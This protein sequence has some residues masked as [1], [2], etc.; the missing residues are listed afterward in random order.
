MTIRSALRVVLAALAVLPF[1][2]APHPALAKAKA[3]ADEAAPAPAKKKSVALGVIEGKKNPEVRGWVRDVVQTNFEL[4]D[5]E[6]FKVKADDASVAK[7]AKDLGVEAVILGKLEKG[8]LLLSVRDGATGKQLKEIELKAP[9]GPKMKA[10]VE[11]KLPKQLYGAFGLATPAEEAKKKAQAKQEAEEAGAEEEGS[12]GEAAAEGDKGEGGDAEEPEAEKP[13]EEEKPGAD[14]PREATS[15]PLDL[16]AGLHFSKRDFTFNDTLSQ[17]LPNVAV[18]HPLRDYHATLDLS[19]FLKAQF[20]PGALL[21]AQGLGANLGLVGGFDFGIPS[22]TV[23]TPA[24]GTQRT[25]TSSVQD[26]YLG[27][28]W[29]VPFSSAAELGFVASYGQQKYILKGDETEA[30]VPDVVYSSL[31]LS[32][33]VYA[34]LGA[35]FVEG[36]LGARLVLDTGE[37]QTIWF[38][39][40]GGRAIEAALNVGYQVSPMIAVVAGG[41]FVRYGFDFNPLDTTAQTVAGGAVDQYIGGTLGARF[42]LP[43]S[44]AVAGSSE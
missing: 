13:A 6:D 12:D 30:L 14:S 25:L 44:P 16:R 34:G 40:V 27:A 43:G 1:A 31:R 32:A 28:R 17:L 29:R 33:D 39:H 35:L 5:A 26:F 3:K 19:L 38:K 4:T 37:L 20:Y 21:G 15:T 11:K 23:Y 8:R 7:M 9:L 22:K 2:A 42:T 24:G 10:A 41:E 36:K 18:I